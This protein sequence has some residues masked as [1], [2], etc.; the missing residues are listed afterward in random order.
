MGF[1]EVYPGDN[2]CR[3]TEKQ[4]F[5]NYFFCE[6][7]VNELNLLNLS[8]RNMRIYDFL[9]RIAVARKKYSVKFFLVAIPLFILAAIQ[10]IIFFMSGKDESLQSL[11]IIEIIVFIATIAFAV[12]MLFVFN[13]LVEPLRLANQALENY[14]ESR[15]IPELPLD[16]EDEAGDLLSNIQDTITELDKLIVEKSDMVDLLSHD[17]RSPVARI[18]SLS[19]LIKID[20]ETGKDVYADYITN[21]CAGLLSMLENILLILKEDN[22]VFRLEFVNLSKLIHETLSFFNF[23]AAEKKL[24]IKVHIDDK[25]YIPVQA[26][27]FKQAIRNIIGNAIKFSPDG[28]AITISG[29]QDNDEITLVIRDEGLGFKPNDM[30]KIFDRF[31]T[32]GKKGTHG[33]ASTGLG[34]YLSKKIIE[35]HGGKLVASS[36][37]ENKGAAF[38]IILYRLIIKKPQDKVL[39]RRERESVMIFRRR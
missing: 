25:I 23:A 16:Y 15:K 30:K 11:Q 39:K 28:K 34:L 6:S 21:E 2:Y 1:I 31:T 33:E 32:A 26:Q 9:S 14:V 20:E 7:F 4:P 22:H 27:L 38:T 29:S 3:M 13:K 18:M 17:V 8:Y 37:G 36:D 19:S 10:L 5:L 35:K 12:W 24:E